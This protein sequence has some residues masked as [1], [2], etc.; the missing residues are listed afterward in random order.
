MD[1][2]IGPKEKLDR[3]NGPMDLDVADWLLLNLDV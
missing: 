3:P 1:E 2:A